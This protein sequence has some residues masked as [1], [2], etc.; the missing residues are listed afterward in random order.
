MNGALLSMKAVKVTASVFGAQ[1]ARGGAVHCGCG[2]RVL[3]LVLASRRPAAPR[4]EFSLT[5]LVS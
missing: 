2:S 4:L 1:A 3:C 5:K